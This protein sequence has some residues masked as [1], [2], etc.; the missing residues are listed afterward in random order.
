MGGPVHGPVCPECGADLRLGRAIRIGRRRRHPLVIGAGITLL[1]VALGISGVE[2]WRTKHQ[3][4]WNAL[5]PVWWLKRE[6]R[7]ANAASAAMARGELWLRLRTGALSD[8]QISDLV[9]L[10]LVSQAVPNV[11]MPQVWTAFIEEAWLR[12]KASGDQLRRYLEAAVRSGLALRLRDRVRQGAEMVVA[13]DVGASRPPS[14][15]PMPTGMRWESAFGMAFALIEVKLGGVQFPMRELGERSTWRLAVE[16]GRGR[17]S[18]YGGTEEF[19]EG[20]ALAAFEVELTGHLE[21]VSADTPVVRAVADQATTD[22]VRRSITA[23]A[24]AVKGGRAWG[25]MLV[26]QP[27]VGFV[28]EVFWRVGEKTWK[29]GY[30]AGSKGRDGSGELF[31]PLPEFDPG[32]AAVD[33]LLRATVELAEVSGDGED[34]WVGEIVFEDVPLRRVAAPTP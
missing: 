14:T 22:A 1:V 33:V 34:A 26:R 15:M 31:M 28:G 4:G 10:A 27:P 12:N 23:E 9:E 32:A 3:S 16:I 7:S 25:T 17:P 18:A 11:P 5:K 13:I 2:A 8:S 30:L 24:L 19:F 21:V 6:A 29:V 20:S